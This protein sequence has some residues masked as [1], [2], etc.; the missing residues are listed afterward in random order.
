MSQTERL[1][2]LLDA[3]EELERQATPGPYRVGPINY[4]DIYGSDGELVALVP[5]GED[6][7]LPNV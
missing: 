1:L 3:Q 6:W 5:K 2:A 4:A 7:T